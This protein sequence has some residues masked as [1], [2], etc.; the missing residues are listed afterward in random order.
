MKLFVSKTEPNVFFAYE[1]WENQAAI[2]FHNKQV[3]V[4]DIFE[5]ANTAL[6]SEPE[7]MHLEDSVFPAYHLAKPANV[8]D[9]LIVIF[10][11]IKIKENLLDEVLNEFPRQ[12]ELTR[13]EDG[14]RL[15]NLYKITETNDTFVVYEN[16]RSQ[17]ALDNHFKLAY[18]E[19]MGKLLTEA[20]EGPLPSH[21]NF[22]TE[23]N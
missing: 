14:N 10:F 18:S 8:E 23:I 7:I 13:K 3:Y 15:F 11:I 1:R 12:I 2:D 17:S 5:L 19:E 20:V 22:V 21:M 6:I 9:D 16:W 4:K